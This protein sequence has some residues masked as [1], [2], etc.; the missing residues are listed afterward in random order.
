[1]KKD[2]LSVTWLRKTSTQQWSNN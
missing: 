2:L 1:V